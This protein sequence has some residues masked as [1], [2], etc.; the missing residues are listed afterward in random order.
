[1]ELAQSMAVDGW[2]QDVRD[3][4]VLIRNTKKAECYFL[5]SNSHS[6]EAVYLAAKLFP[7]S[8][9]IQDTSCMNHLHHVARF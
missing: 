1:M 2:I 8:Q 6:V 9:A 7:D 4:P 3:R 5:L